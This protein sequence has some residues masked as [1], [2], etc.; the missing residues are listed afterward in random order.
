[1]FGARD[2]ELRREAR[3]ARRVA[4]LDRLLKADQARLAELRGCP[5][6]GQQLQCVS[7]SC[8]LC[9]RLLEG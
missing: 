5:Y 2:R 9:E 3:K 8:R 6:A 1:M 7:V 4:Q